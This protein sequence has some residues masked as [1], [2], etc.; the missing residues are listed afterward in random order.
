MACALQALRGVLT[1]CDAHG[2]A[3]A[4][5]RFELLSCCA[6]VFLPGLLVA[7]GRGLLAATLPTEKRSRVPRAPVGPS[8]PVWTHICGSAVYAATSRSGRTLTVAYP[9]SFAVL[10]EVASER[11]PAALGDAVAALRAIDGAAA[12]LHLLRTFCR[13]SGSG[14]SR[15]PPL[16]A[17]T[18]LKSARAWLCSG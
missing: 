17:R 1:A 13:G 9:H 18:A 6:R 8:R 12:I 5:V 10:W 15:H 11:W 14:H 2:I 4:C 16:P 7:A 3:G